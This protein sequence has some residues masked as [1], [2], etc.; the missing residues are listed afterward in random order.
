MNTKKLIVAALMLC[1]TLPSMAQTA[2]DPIKEQVISIIKNKPADAQKQI[3]EIEKL[4]KKSAS[5]MASIAKAYLSEKDYAT[6]TA[7]GEKA[8]AL[9]NKSKDPNEKSDVYVLMGNIAVGQDN[10]GDAAM[11]FQQA[12]NANPQDPT[13][14]R[15]YAQIMSKTDPQGSIQTLENLRKARPDYPVDAI[16][17]DI[18]HESGNMKDAIKYYSK[19]KFDDMQE[20][21]VS[22]YSTDLFLSKEYDQSLELAQ[23]GHAK[24]EKNASFNRLI[25]FNNVEKKDYNAAIAGGDRLFASDSTK[26]GVRDY[27]YMAEAQKGLNQYDKAIETYKQQQNYEGLDD[28]SKNAIN[29]SISDSYIEL[30]DYD[31]AAKYLKAYLDGSTTK[32][33]DTDEL[34]PKFYAA[35]VT[36]EKSSAETKQAMYAKADQA[37]AELAEKYP[38]YLV[39]VT[40]LRARLCFSLEGS[41]LEKLKMAAPHYQTIATTLEAKSD[42]NNAENKELITAYNALIANAVHNDNDMESAKVLSEKVIVLD[43]E[44]AS[45]KAILGM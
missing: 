20:Y 17:A 31:N 30:S 12:I 19:V 18:A 28:A 21:Q 15:R 43:P 36:D 42:R 16:A 10:G 33:F 37:Y 24:W 38:N 9:A 41:D 32:N 40:D 1:A 26:H 25:L 39:Y 35:Q 27:Y 11:W 44:N 23:K 29:K 5:G 6:A 8:V 7:Y 2:T 34:L 45:A 22:Y 13:G 4:Q 3:K 14:Y